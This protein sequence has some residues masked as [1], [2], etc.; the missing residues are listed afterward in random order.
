M[1][2][3][4]PLFP[5]R[6][7]TAEDWRALAESKG[8]SI[9]QL[10]ISFAAKH[11][12]VGTPQHVAETIDRHVQNDA[13]DGFVIVGHTNPTGLDD[14]VDRVVPELQERGV[15][16]AEYGEGATLRQ[17]LGLPQPLGV[18]LRHSRDLAGARG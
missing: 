7:K 17:T 6:V 5:D 18:T 2:G 9:R 8:Y 11:T 16:R 3:R 1:Q 12:F 10:V 14:F 15:Y 13:S 4:V